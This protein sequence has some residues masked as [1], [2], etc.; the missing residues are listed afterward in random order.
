MREPVPVRLAATLMLVRDGVEGLEV[1]MVARHRA[2][3]FASGAL[4]FPG[5]SVDP[6]DEA[7]GAGCYG[8][9]EGALRVAALRETFEECGVMLAKEAEG[10]AWLSAV[11]A[12]EIGAGAKGATFTEI[13]ARER[14]RLGLDALVPFAHWIT[15]PISPKRFDTAFYIAET[16][17]GQLARHDG[18]EAVDS[19]WISP[20][21]AL[22]AA[23]RGDY[24]IVPVTQLN[25]RMLG[26]SA[27]VASAL[28]AARA[29]RIV[30]VE[31]RAEKL[32]KGWRM[33]IPLEAGY[34]VD[35]F[36]L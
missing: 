28:H 4:V 22:A 8:A 33:H 1:F 17:Q 21:L 29:R 34:G 6:G 9:R 25:L 23:E 15:P 26:N 36:D 24:T 30:T 27:D 12:A 14:L 32:G 16:P 19:V 20:V 7:L 10:E 3:E 31:P 11:R 5:G 18:S 35:H 13:V 2:I